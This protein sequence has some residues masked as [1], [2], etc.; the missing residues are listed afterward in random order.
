VLAELTE[1]LLA[2]P[3]GSLT[4]RGFSMILDGALEGRHPGVQ[5][6]VAGDRS[7]CVQGFHRY[8]TAGHGTDVTLDVAWRRPGCP[9]RHR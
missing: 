5:L 4:E 9:E 6:I 2:S 3:S 8:A 7:G 1:V